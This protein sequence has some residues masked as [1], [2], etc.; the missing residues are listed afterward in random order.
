MSE[1]K[2]L[3]VDYDKKALDILAELLEAENIKVIKATDGAVA[4][5]KY[6][7]EMPNLVILEAMLPKLHGFELTQKITQKSKGKVPVFI[8]TAVYKGHQYRNEALR[9]FGAT[10]Y[11]EKPYNKDELMESV[12]KYLR[13]KDDSD[14]EIPDIPDLPSADSVIENLANKLK[15]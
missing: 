9:T 13:D 2:V 4:Y 10:G 6:E 3:I 8:V 5:E 1:K 11:F 15:K 12:M 7:E 14:E